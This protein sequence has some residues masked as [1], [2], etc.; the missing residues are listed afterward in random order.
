MRVVRTAVVA[1]LYS[2]RAVSH[3]FRNSACCDFFTSLSLNIFSNARMMNISLALDLLI[4]LTGGQGR[5]RPPSASSSLARAERQSNGR[6]YPSRRTRQCCGLVCVCSKNRLTSI[7]RPFNN[8]YGRAD[9]VVLRQRRLHHTYDITRDE[10]R[11]TEAAEPSNL[12]NPC[13]FVISQVPTG[14]STDDDNGPPPPR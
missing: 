10:R 2:L 8:A 14:C 9:T 3:S 4:M 7:K 5:G 13:N 6:I 1:Y 12:V 11:Q